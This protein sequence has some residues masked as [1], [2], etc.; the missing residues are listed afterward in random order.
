MKNI[1]KISL[2][3]FSLATVAA[4]CERDKGSDMAGKGGSTTL[5]VTPKHH[6]SL[7][8]DCTIYIK[9]NAQDAA[10]VYDDSV[11]CVDN[12][13]GIPVATFAN[14]KKGKYYLLGDGFDP[15]IAQK[16]KG[17]APYVIAQDGATLNYNLS[18]TEGD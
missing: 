14:L 12:S 9:Y 11:K 5:N 7:I 1:L 17:G 6:D 15:R 4:S 2:L 10:T 3:A 8:H 16:V 13:D 18:V